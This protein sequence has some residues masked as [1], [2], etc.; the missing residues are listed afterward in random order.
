V[1]GWSRIRFIWHNY[2]HNVALYKGGLDFTRIDVMPNQLPNVRLVFE[3]ALEFSSDVER[4][5]YLNQIDAAQPGIR[6]QVA[7]LLTANAEVGSFL[8]TPPTDGHPTT[9]AQSTVETPGTNVGPYKLLQQIG[10]G[11]MGVVFMAEQLH[12][13]HRTVAIKIIKP[14]MD[15]RQVIARFDAERQA[16]AM[17][18][19]PNIARVLDAGTTDSGRPYFVM[20][21]VKGIPITKYCD[22]KHL[23]LR[24]RLELFLPVCQAVQHAHQK[25]IIHRDIK[26]TNVL[27]AE[28]DNHA[29]PKVIDFGVAKATAQK[30]TEC[31]MFT[32][33]GQLVGTFEYMSPEQAKLNQLD[34]DTRSDIY[35]LGVMLYEL[36]TGT[37]PFEPKRL[38]SAAFDEVLRII[39]DEEPPK[40]S[41]RL[42]NSTELPTI[43]ANRGLEA[44]EISTL[45][46]GELDW[47]VMKAL[48]KDRNHRYETP[49][50]FAADIQRYLN[51][52]AVHACPPSVLYRF[53]KFARRNRRPLVAAGLIAFA[54]IAGTVASTWQ[55]IRATTAENLAEARLQNERTAR[56]E[57]LAQR[58]LAETERAAAEAQRER[59]TTEAVRATAVAEFLQQ[60]IG[61]ADPYQA[62][63]AGYTVQDLLDEA[64]HGL[65]NQFKNQPEVEA[66]I[67]STI[68]VAYF[69]LNLYE[70]AKPHLEK[71]AELRRQT[72]GADHVQYA[73][74]LVALG[75][76][77]GSQGNDD[78]A[79][80]DIR[81]ALSIYRTHGVDPG[82]R[83]AALRVLHWMGEDVYTEALDVAR[84]LPDGGHPDL[85][86]IMHVQAEFMA[87]NGQALVG[88]E[89]ARQAL[90]M[91][92]RFQPREHPE[93]GWA[94]WTLGLTL[95]A[96]RKLAEAENEYRAALELFVDGYGLRPESRGI[97]RSRSALIRVLKAQSKQIETDALLT[98]S[99]DLQKQEHRSGSITHSAAVRRGEANLTLAKWSEALVELDAAALAAPDNDVEFLLRLA[100][101]FGSAA[102]GLRTYSPTLVDAARARRQEAYFRE[103]FLKQ[104]PDHAEVLACTCSL[105]ECYHEL[106]RHDAALEK[107]QHARALLITKLDQDQSANSIAKLAQVYVMLGRDRDAGELVDEAFSELEDKFGAADLD[108][109]QTL[110]DLGSRFSQLG[111]WAAAAE[112]YSQAYELTPNDHGLVLS[113]ASPALACG[114]FELYHHVCSLALEQFVDTEDTLP[115]DRVAKAGLL[116]APLAE[117]LS[118]F[119]QLAEVAAEKGKDHQW[120]YYF[121]MV[122]GMAAYRT[123]DW[124]GTLEWCGRSREI[125]FAPNDVLNSLFEAMAHH[126]LGHADEARE[127][128]DRAT[129]ILDDHLPQLKGNWGSDWGDWLNCTIVR[130]EAE[131]LVNNKS[132]ST[133]PASQ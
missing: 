121:Q 77:R 80:A 40:P 79:K 131:A 75:W 101:G 89:L 103:Q 95:E 114:D 126:Q 70:D 47:V 56:Q 31:T 99:G 12:P 67:R 48:E 73:D 82:R 92:L 46:Q 42:S 26:P 113:A 52:E 106:G 27:V 22:D 25:G 71:A 116:T 50:S 14:G 69:H 111:E 86:S 132:V 32:E 118:Q 110:K 20:E 59:A 13:L 18:D 3:R 23:T 30:L 74:S 63:G 65:E 44:N 84:E 76:N 15:T 34:I 96:Q 53:R 124:R 112:F 72:L 64:S 127:A 6:D 93:V 108:R 98:R 58:K 11:G 94:L 100:N 123:G 54:L 39:R 4:E 66:D 36:L 91:H 41:T 107:V 19:H 68:G 129:K 128:M 104:A 2:H 33:F 87:E 24:E 8:E 29:I 17:M 28:Y 16:L 43:A 21:L 122:R 102:S 7:A 10:E 81:E 62:K 133:P 90:E 38:R 109:L 85:A 37:T 117:Q 9:P 97:D 45:V 125:Q 120:A 61:S 119:A 57:A 78:Q 88:E 49:N 60:L 35:S 55:A 51:D 5:E 105:A 83:L 115:A 130:R 1:A